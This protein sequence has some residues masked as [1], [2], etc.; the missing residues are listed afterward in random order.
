MM[1]YKND[2][3]FFKVLKQFV[4]VVQRG[5]VRQGHR[6]CPVRVRFVEH[7]VWSS[8]CEGGISG[9]CTSSVLADDKELVGSG[10]F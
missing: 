10:A 7:R 5:H 8:S 9:S 1:V 4:V 3:V 2:R 6:V